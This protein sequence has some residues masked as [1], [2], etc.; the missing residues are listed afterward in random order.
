MPWLEVLL[1]PQL[2]RFPAQ[3]R[4]QALRKAREATFDVV[5]LVGIA[6]GL[7]LVTAL[8]RYQAEAYDALERVAAVLV[9][10]VIAIP[11]L[12]V[13]VVPFLVRRVRRG[14]DQEVARRSA[15]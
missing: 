13:F 10:F 4:A 1:Y 9:N 5:E 7:V 11:L 14:L 15:P 6:L 3:E 12:L 8:T 2:R